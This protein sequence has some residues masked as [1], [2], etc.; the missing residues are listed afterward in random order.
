MKKRATIY[1]IAKELGISTATVNR[2]LTGKPKVSGETRRIVLKTAQEMGFQP[3]SLAR[4]LARRPIHLAVVA[5]TSFPEFHQSFV[6]GAR[7]TEEELRDYNMQV[8]YFIYDKGMFNSPEVQA[9]LEETLQIIA[10]Q[11][12]DG[13]L[14][15]S[16]QAEGFRLLREKGVLVATAVNDV[17]RDLRKF[18]VR[19]N[20]RVAG[21]IAAELL[22]RTMDRTKQVA[23]AS[24]L[25]GGNIHRETEEGFMEQMQSTPLSVATIYHNYDDEDRAYRETKRVLQQYPGLGAIYVNSFNSR[26]VVWAVKELGLDGKLLLITSDIFPDLRQWIEEGTV[27]ASIYQNQRSQGRVGLK[28]LYQALADNLEVE[29]TVLVKPRIILNSNLELF[30]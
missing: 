26:G 13:C 4:S 11:G 9:Y 14:I 10:G 24:G 8:D 1:D 12:Y 30:P 3:N 19:Y 25:P 5:I 29:D 2:A 16:K 17:E 20:G 21:R 23:I 15:C 7:E 18:C 27:M 28:F 22:W 6:E